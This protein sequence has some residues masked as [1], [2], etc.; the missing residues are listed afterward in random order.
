VCKVLI[1]R[2][3]EKREGTGNRWRNP[4]WSGK[5]AGYDGSL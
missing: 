3:M 4:L 1:I 5:T 2:E